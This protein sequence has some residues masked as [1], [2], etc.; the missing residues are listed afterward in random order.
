MK[1]E[2][3]YAVITGDIVNS[4]QIDTKQR[5]L[6]LEVLKQSFE[7]VEKLLGKNGMGSSF[8]IYRGD[9]FQGVLAVPEYA[10]LAT[11]IIRVN[12]RQSFAASL[13]QL[14]DARM[15]VGIGEIEFFSKKGAEGDG[16]AYRRSGPVLDEMKGESRL[17]FRTPWEEADHELE[18]ACALMD[19][20]ISKWSASQAEAILLQIE[21]LTQQ[22]IADKLQITQAAVNYR[23]RSAGWFAIDQFLKHYKM[24]IIQKAKK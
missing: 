13:K 11:L 22:N 7:L 6:L 21:G 10:L 5:N 24:L 1:K 18:V 2:K 8:S 3:L 9:S 14:W 20:V 19:V 15:G 4:S 16:I 12:L 23:L 17:Q